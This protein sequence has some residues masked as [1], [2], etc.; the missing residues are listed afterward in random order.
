M[1]GTITRH[2]QTVS[3]PSRGSSWSRRIQCLVATSILAIRSD[4]DVLSQLARYV[5]SPASTPTNSSSLAGSPANG[6]SGK[7]SC[8][9]RSARAQNSLTAH[10]FSATENTLAS[11]VQCAYLQLMARQSGP[12]PSVKRSTQLI[13]LPVTINWLT[14]I[15]EGTQ[16]GQNDSSH[17]NSTKPQIR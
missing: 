12:H 8:A 5:S 14:K 6:T 17:S 7:V 3:R 16:V 2:A 10:M 15:P 1:P 9:Q 11:L 13:R 4:L